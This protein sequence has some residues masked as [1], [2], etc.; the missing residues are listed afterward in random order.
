ML[1]VYIYSDQIDIF[2]RLTKFVN[3]LAYK[4]KAEKRGGEQLYIQRKKD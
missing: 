1:T 3:F 2:T 4:H